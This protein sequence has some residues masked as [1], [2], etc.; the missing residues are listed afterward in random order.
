M[1]KLLTC[2]TIISKGTKCYI[3]N[4]VPSGDGLIDR[5]VPNREGRTL[6]AWTSQRWAPLPSCLSLHGGGPK[7][8]GT[9]ASHFLL[10]AS[11][12]LSGSADWWQPGLGWAGWSPLIA[13]S[14]PIW[15]SSIGITFRG[16]SWRPW[17]CA[18]PG[19][20]GAIILPLFFQ[21]SLPYVSIPDLLVDR[22]TNRMSGSHF[23]DI[24][25]F[26]LQV[27]LEI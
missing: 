26:V 15:M 4:T 3:K 5:T 7:K 22:S 13:R 23:Q 24:P 6:I 1:W 17:H 20:D 25:S 12:E 11:E 19:G 9:P 8:H 2:V 16:C 14:S 21:I 18:N 27:G 10:Q